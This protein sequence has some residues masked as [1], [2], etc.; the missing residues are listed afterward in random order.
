MELSREKLKQRQQELEQEMAARQ[1]RNKQ[2]Q[3]AA[4]ENATAIVGLQGKLQEIVSL[5]ACLSLPEP[6]ESEDQ[7]EE[8][9]ADQL[10]APTPA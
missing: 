9:A 8:E 3:A 4:N 2:I 6:D 10:A 1:E 7:A 5:L